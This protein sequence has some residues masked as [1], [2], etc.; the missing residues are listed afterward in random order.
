MTKE[1]L[2]EIGKYEIVSRNGV[3][4]IKMSS[5]P[6]PEEGEAIDDTLPQD[7]KDMLNGQDI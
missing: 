3:F 6:E 7:V 4:Y 2:F 1:K 5:P